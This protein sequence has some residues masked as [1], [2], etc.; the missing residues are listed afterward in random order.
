MRSQVKAFNPFT[1]RTNRNKRRKAYMKSLPAGVVKMG[2]GIILIANDTGRM[3][4]LQRALPDEG[5]G[6]WCPPG[7]CCNENEPPELAA[8]RET[9][10]EAGYACTAPLIEVH[11]RTTPSGF[12]FTNYMAEIP[13]EFTPNL[14][15]EH[16]DY[17]WVSSLDEVP[18]YPPFAE[19]VSDL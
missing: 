18:L 13:T 2:A 6:Y 4:L 14:S 11:V 10:E 15:M 19:A 16:C 9:L 3:L 7:G 12:V 8:L 5:A 17:R 1:T